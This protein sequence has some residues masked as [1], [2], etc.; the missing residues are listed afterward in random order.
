MT[1]LLGS[2]VPTA[3]DADDDFNMI[4]GLRHRR[5]PR[6]KPRPSG[7]RHVFGRNGGWSTAGAGYSSERN[8]FLQNH[9]YFSFT[10]LRFKF[11]IERF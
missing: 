10:F 2:I 7:S 8:R 6:L 9:K 11:R 5:M 4:N 1:L 3:V